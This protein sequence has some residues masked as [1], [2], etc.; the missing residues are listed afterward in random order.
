M[1]TRAA[2]RQARDRLAVLRH[3]DEVTGKRGQ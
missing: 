1:S 2:D 3:A